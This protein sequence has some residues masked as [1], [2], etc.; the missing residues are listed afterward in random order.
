MLVKYNQSAGDDKIADFAMTAKSGTVS[1]DDAFAY[2]TVMGDMRVIHEET[3]VTN[4]GETIT[5]AAMNGGILAQG[6]AIA[7]DHSRRLTFVAQVLRF[8]TDR[9]TGKQ[10]AIFTN[11]GVPINDGMRTNSGAGADF[12]IGP[13]YRVW[14]DMDG[15]VNFSAIG[16]DG[17]RVNL[18]RYCHCLNLLF[19]ALL[20]C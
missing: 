19:I 5:G 3:I 6:N 13:D 16:D 9:R 17:G 10:S 20:R 4:S 15:F 2:L 8:E 12:D 1:Q 7:H 14:P 11:G 18:R